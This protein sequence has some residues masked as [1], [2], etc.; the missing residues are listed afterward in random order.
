M[1]IGK[2]YRQCTKL[3][4]LGLSRY[5]PSRRGCRAGCGKQRSIAIVMDRREQHIGMS[6]ADFTSNMVSST[7]AEL[8]HGTLNMQPVT[9]TGLN[10][11]SDTLGTR[12]QNNVIV[13]ERTP[14]QRCSTN[15]SKFKLCLA[16]VRSIKPKSA[17]LL[18]YITSRKADLFAITETWLTPL[19]VAAKLQ[20]VPPG[21]RFV[22]RPRNDRAAGGIGLL[23]RDAIAVRKI[24]DGEKESF[25][26]SEWKIPSGSGFKIE[27]CYPLSSTILQGTSCFHGN[28][29]QRIL[30]IYGV[31]YFGPRS[32]HYYG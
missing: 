21:Y 22:H 8:A 14:I 16:N 23:Y 10:I 13:V 9:S 2:L 5:K 18:N 12:N 26:F 7:Y 28:F 30:S 19:D 32:A 4:G 24:D 6:I 17:A 29:L 25:E 20:I 3:A 31:H 27:V 11:Q 1:K 15:D